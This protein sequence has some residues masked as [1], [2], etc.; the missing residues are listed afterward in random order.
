MKNMFF[1]I[2]LVF[3]IIF[4]GSFIIKTQ[5]DTN[6]HNACVISY[7]SVPMGYE[8]FYVALF[9]EGPRYFV[10]YKGHTRWNGEACTE[11]KHVDVKEYR[12]A[13]LIVGEIK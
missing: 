9:A 4:V 5:N 1:G 8:S 3:A 7:P 11:Q 2:A 13:K 12:R 6:Y 10:T